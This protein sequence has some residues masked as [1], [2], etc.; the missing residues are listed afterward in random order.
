VIEQRLEND[1]AGKLLRED[2]RPG[3][4]VVVEV[5]DDGLVLKPYGGETL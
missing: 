2:L 3:H 1:I 4:S 5:K